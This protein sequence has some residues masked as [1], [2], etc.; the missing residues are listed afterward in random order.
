MRQSKEMERECR[1]GSG[2]EEGHRKG[3]SARKIGIAR[4]MGP[5]KLV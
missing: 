3:L 1:G 2:Y 4:V 5:G